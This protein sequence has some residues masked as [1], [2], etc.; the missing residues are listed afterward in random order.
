MVK[1]QYNILKT[2]N[3]SY[4]RI[5]YID[6]LNSI[7]SKYGYDV[8]QIYHAIVYLQK[9]N[10]ISSTTNIEK[11]HKGFICISPEGVMVLLAYLESEEQRKFTEKLSKR[12]LIISFISTTA[13]LIQSIIVLV[14]FIIA[15]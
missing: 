4:D 2:L 5:E 14:Q 15:R 7:R 1:L 9:I 13:V 8:N 3:D 6:L 11:E 12:S 10:Y